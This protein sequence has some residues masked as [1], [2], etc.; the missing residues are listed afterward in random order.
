[1]P[2]PAT[3]TD[4]IGLIRKSGLIDEYT[5][6]NIALDLPREPAACAD[7]LVE[8]EL[9]TAFQAKQLLAG[10]AKG[11]VLGAYRV[12]RQL[13]KGG[14]GVVYLAEHVA[15]GRQVAVKVLNE[16]QSH[17]KLALERFFREA[18]AAAALDHP[19]IVRL[20]DI[21]QSQGTHFLVME[22]VDGTDLQALVDQIGPLQP[23]QAVG[24][25]AQT[26]A[27]LQHAHD[28]G[29]IHRDIKPAN[30]IV[31]KN[32]TVKVLD[33]GLARSVCNPN[34][35]LT[36]QLDEDV[37]TGTADFLSPEQALNVKLDS[38]TDIYSLGATLYTL[39]TGRAPY[40]GG[41]GQKLAQHQMA[42]PPDVRA[43]RPDVPEQ[44]A[45]VVVRMMA[46]RPADRYQTARA[47][48]AALAPWVP[49]VDPGSDVTHSLQSAKTTT[50]LRQ[51]A[52]RPVRAPSPSP[53]RTR[54]AFA[55]VGGL[56]LTAGLLIAGFAGSGKRPGAD[57]APGGTQPV[58]PSAPRSDTLCYSLE[59]SAV[60]PFTFTYKDGAPD[61]PVW[62]TH[63]PSGVYLHC[64]K[65]ES[66][67]EF[68]AAADAGRT[69]I[70]V[71]NLNSDVS[72]QILFQLDEGLNVPLAPGKR[73]RVRLGYRT[74]NDAEG[75]AFVR[76]PKNGD[77][78]SIADVRLERT[79]GQWM[80][81]EM[82]FRR[83][84]EG[85]I[86]VCVINNAVGEGNALGIGALEVIETEPEH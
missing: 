82:T 79:R 39:L 47:A 84:S 40:E 59:L 8:A 48:R 77:F 61:D 60:R 67:A 19:N 16:E 83:P 26:A 50:D 20:H 38:R 58:A 65:R 70:G 29:F 27:G 81:A 7:A 21:A 6:A 56:L 10:R 71:T 57:P 52:P 17:E 45:E 75:A 34:D 9:L 74:T 1:M 28:R 51:P 33:M 4:L 42:P 78:S 5:L 18:R 36:G 44:L 14:M 46:K 23:A 35:E 15:L 2:S 63:V 43:V 11:L 72:S 68:R 69:W 80:T 12:L 37:V 73:Y 53:N 85:K 66:V 76:N 24:Y 31:A 22:F 55:C 64:W 41:T 25:I 54:L 32:G 13:G 62:N 49:G 86:D 3:V 30:L